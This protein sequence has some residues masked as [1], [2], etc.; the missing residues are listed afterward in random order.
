M[1]SLF[2]FVAIVGV[3][4]AIGYGGLYLLAYK[5]EPQPKEVTQPLG[6]LKIRKQ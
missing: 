6:N 5:F 4:A 1:P 2:R 3:L